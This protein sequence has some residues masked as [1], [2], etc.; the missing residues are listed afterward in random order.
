MIPILFDSEVNGNV[1]KM[2]NEDNV[3][4]GVRNVMEFKFLLT[5]A[6]FMLSAHVTKAIWKHI[7]KNITDTITMRNLK[8]YSFF[9]KII[10]TVSEQS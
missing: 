4:A 6:R 9:L 8:C 1:C 7:L 5:R 3:P 10:I 2:V